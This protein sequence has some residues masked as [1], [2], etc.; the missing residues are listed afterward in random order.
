MLYSAGGLDPLTVSFWRFLGGAVAL[1]AAW[2]L[3]RGGPGELSLAGRFRAEPVRFVG[4]G[5]GMAVS[6][7]AYFAALDYAGVAVATVVTLGAAPILVAVGARLW[8]SERLGGRGVLIIGSALAGLTLLV[9]GGDPDATATAPVLGIGLALLSAVGH[10]GTILLGRAMGTGDSVGGAL[11][12]FAVGSLCLLP[13]ALGS[14]LGP[15]GGVTVTAVVLLAYLGVVPSA[16]AYGL[17]FVGLR[18]VSATTASVV[19]LVEP[20][21]AAGIAVAFLG[22]RLTV[23]AAL[24]GVMLLAAVVFSGPPRR[25]RPSDPAV[26]G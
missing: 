21:V 5:V 4:T 16:L 3:L 12:G 22:E 1:A 19:A 26:P 20:L 13:F 25:S 2:P 15:D 23:A 17:F 10:A 14:G 24:G 18:V 6:Q 11:I 7:T 9:S 8:M